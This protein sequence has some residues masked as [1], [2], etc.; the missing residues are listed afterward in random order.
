[1]TSNGP[2]AQFYFNTSELLA[3]GITQAITMGDKFGS[4]YSGLGKLAICEFSSPNIAKP[5]HIGHLRSTIIGSFL[6]KLLSLSGWQTVSINYLG[7]WGKQYG[8][9]AVGYEK[10]GSEK[11]LLEDPIKH[12]YEVYVK[13][14]AEA[15]ENE[16][17]HDEA[18]AYFKKMEDGN[19]EALALWQRF[20]D[21]SIV[22][23][24]ETYARLNIVFDVYSGE[25]QYSLSQMKNVL[26]ELTN[27]NLI[28]TDGGALIVDLK[29][30]SLG[31]AVIG[32]SDGSMLYLSRDIA[33]AQDRYNYYDFDK[34]FYCVA[35]QQD[36]HFRQLFKI[37]ELSGKSWVSKCE[38]I[39]FG[40]IKSK[41]GNMST[42]K[43]TVVF[44][45]DIL[46]NVKEEM[47]AVMK[48]NEDKYKQVENPEYVSDVVGMS[49]IKIQD[50]AAK[51]IKD[52]AFDWARMLSFEGD[53]GPY[54][55]YAHARMCSIERLS[56]YKLNE[57]TIKNVDL[58]VLVEPQ[59]LTLMEQV[60]A[61]PDVI[62]EL[63]VSLEPCGLVKYAL[64]LSHAVSS[65]I[66]VLY[67]TGQPAEIA[68]P[69]LAMYVSARICLGNSL[70]MLGLEPLQ[71]M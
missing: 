15:S 27:K 7:D 12:L 51:R 4:N 9:L 2:F 41:D 6:Q 71:R 38:H 45:A 28:Q 59:A 69:R 66:T 20:R 17:I 36:H 61:F 50:M 23:Y 54:L 70:R 63:S 65:A 21:L 67:V 26:D 8:L 56:E 25:S 30:H 37:L 3:D 33:A 18:R 43:G 13:I 58:S 32:K 16:D 19:S 42:R 68:K 35:S 1:V 47:H 55:Q 53:T 64:R 49:A 44:L 52:Y 40:L 57:Q 60:C 29:E 11:A 62:R 39:S 48:K 10:F 31:T 14:N 24:Q 46:D 34:M 5:F 22:K